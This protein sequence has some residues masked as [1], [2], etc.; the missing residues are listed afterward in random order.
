MNDAAQ[1]FAGEH[2]FRN[3]CKAD[4]VNVKSFVR[5]I[6]SFNVTRVSEENDP[7]YQLCC[8]TVK[9][10]GFLWHQVVIQFI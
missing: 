1:L 4:I 10:T 6:L 8:M 9:G 5:T 7:R 3:F 2:D